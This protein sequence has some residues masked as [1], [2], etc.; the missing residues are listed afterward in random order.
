MELAIYSPSG[1]E[2][3]TMPEIFEG[4]VEK[5]ELMS[6]DSIELHFSLAEPV[7]FPVGSHCD[8]NGKRYEVTET[9]SPSYNVST[10]GYDYTLK[11]DAYYIAWGQRLYKYF[12]EDEWSGNRETTFSLTAVLEEHLRLLC[13]SL[14]AEGYRFNDAEIT[15]NLNRTDGDGLSESKSITYEEATYID[16]LNKIANEWETEWWVV[17]GVINFGKCETG[18]A[19]DFQIGKNVVTMSGSKGSGDY[20]NRL[21]AYGSDK[22]LPNNY[23]KGEAVFTIA[24]I[25]CVNGIYFAKTDKKIQTSYFPK[26]YRQTLGNAVSMKIAESESGGD[27]YPMLN[28]INKQISDYSASSVDADAEA[29]SDDGE[30]TDGTEDATASTAKSVAGTATSESS[31]DI[32]GG[33]GNISG[34]TTIGGSTTII[35]G[36]TSSGGGTSS[37][38]TTIG[39]STTTIG[40]GEKYSEYIDIEPLT[41]GT[42][43]VYWRRRF[44]KGRFASNALVMQDNKIVLEYRN[45][46]NFIYGDRSPAR[47][48]LRFGHT[49]QSAGTLTA[50]GIIK[51]HL[52]AYIRVKSDAGE[53]GDEIKYRATE[54][55]TYTY[56][57]N[58][59][60][61]AYGSD[62]M[63]YIDIGNVV[64]P[65]FEL[66]T[67][68]YV[69][70]NFRFRV[71][72]GTG[73]TLSFDAG[74]FELKKAKEIA[75]V[76]AGIVDADGYDPE[77][78]YDTA[79][80][81]ISRI[82]KNKL[83][84]S[85]TRQLY[86]SMSS[87]E[88][89]AT[90]Y[91]Q[92]LSGSL[93]TYKLNNQWIYTGLRTDGLD[94]G[95]WIRIS[96]DLNGLKV[97][98]VGDTFKFTNIVYGALP[99]YYFPYSLENLK[100]IKAITEPRLSLPA[101]YRIDARE[102]IPDCE[103]VEASV[104]FDDIYPCTEA[105]IVSVRT[106]DF[107]VTDDNGAET[108]EFYTSYYI[109][110]DK[111]E[112]D[113]EYQLDNGE[114]MQIVFQTG[115]LA[116]LTF[117]CYFNSQDINDEEYIKDGQYFKII[118]GEFD[119]G[120]KLPNSAMHPR[121]AAD[122]E[123]ENDTTHYVDG[124]WVGDKFIL[125]GWNPQ[126][127]P[128][129]G[130]IEAAQ[131]ELKE[132]AEKKLAEMCEDPT[133]Y[134]CTLFPDSAYGLTESERALVKPSGIDTSFA[135]SINLT[136]IADTEE[137][138]LTDGGGGTL[139][140]DNAKVYD[141][142]Q[143]VTLVNRAFFADGQRASRILGYERK[144]DIPW[145]APVYSVGQKAKYSR[146][147]RIEKKVEEN[148]ETKSGGVRS[149]GTLDD[150]KP[151]SADTPF[152]FTD[153]SIENYIYATNEGRW[154]LYAKLTG[155]R[156][157]F[158]IA[159]RSSFGFYLPYQTGDN[160]PLAAVGRTFYIS[161][162]GETDITV[163]YPSS[164]NSSVS[165]TFAKETIAT[166]EIKT[167][168]A[169]FRMQPSL[170]LYYDV[171]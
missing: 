107:H 161:N 45:Y 144:M 26:K 109:K 117:D 137:R 75:T 89:Y 164:A 19:V 169:K 66:Y 80:K 8:W 51:L 53:D 13:R 88:D 32:S 87:A 156:V 128:D 98:A 104:V 152:P 29:V 43:T 153:A 36:S 168:T 48:L 105:E 74:F 96:E 41:I 42:T 148:K 86:M 90:V 116:G 140:H 143:R 94:T 17:D 160:L 123:A 135:P 165:D 38:S 132:E 18:D 100:V 30:T 55:T 63:A 54:T 46:N 99:S 149:V 129:L 67:D 91:M 28:V 103:V 171:E 2:L 59:S 79:G 159:L 122:Y 3:Y 134:D 20:A 97:P 73:L 21:Y 39:G 82:Y 15:Y 95:Y 127:L 163:N 150:V 131:E 47:V 65:E 138:V 23:G 33:T 83:S 133:T 34:S 10:G 147:A 70:V 102:D 12:P 146:L 155:Y 4:C 167:F 72:N 157:Q 111:Y 37:G 145:D 5:A 71:E 24:E 154:V 119:G 77:A 11:F 120:I 113:E 108:D 166:G 50:N 56:K 1:E 101:P 114:N 106:Q 139:N 61:G 136:K 44:P 124:K 126:Y 151:W 130:L 118:R 16:A 7:N 27:C 142:G 110:T 76:D 162:A 49:N 35:D 31:T 85:F 25:A 40:S 121:S 60:V 62:N 57:A 112:F 115:A 158:N 125:T 92:F 52:T 84:I 58:E 68:D 170:W 6:E 9:Q 14:N 93:G 78:Y 81:N 141:I 64:L 22:N 69:A